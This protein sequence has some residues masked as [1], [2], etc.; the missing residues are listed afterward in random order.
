M[1]KK[2]IMRCFIVDTV[3]QILLELI[4]LRNIVRMSKSRVMGGA[5]NMACLGWV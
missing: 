1:E 5:A 3:Q 4:L 2:C